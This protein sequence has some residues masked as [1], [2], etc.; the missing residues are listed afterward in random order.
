MQVLSRGCRCIEIDVWNGDAPA[1]SRD[2][3]KSPHADKGRGLSGSSLSSA[4]LSIVET[5]GDKYET[6]RLYLGDRAVAGHRRSRSP[7]ANRDALAVADDASP[8]TSAVS[9]STPQ[10]PRESGD[11]V[12][13][14]RVTPR[15]R[16]LPR[17][18]PIVTHGW[19]LTIPCGFRDVCEAIKESAFVDN[20]LPVIISLEV[21]AD[22]EQQEVMVSI[23]KE[24][25]HGLLV[26]EP[27][28][29]C[30]PRFRVP[31]L[32]ELRN[33]ILVKV[34]RAAAKMVAG[35]GSGEAPV[36]LHAVDDDDNTSRCH[37]DAALPPHSS[38][39]E[40][41]AP[42]AESSARARICDSLADLAVYTR[43]QRFE[44]LQTPHAKSP[45]HVLSMSENRILDM[46]HKHH[47]DVFV[48][49]KRYFMRAFPNVR[50]I[51]SSNPDPSLFWRKGVQMV[52]LNW[53]NL[54][55]GMMV[56]EGMFADEK[57]W[58]LKP[59]GYQSS[60][61]ASDT[62]ALAAP[63]CTMDLSITVFAGHNLP[64]TAAH[65]DGD[66]DYAASASAIRPL[67]KVE[68]H[69]ERPGGTDSSSGGVKENSY[70]RRTDAKK[71]SN[72]YFGSHGKTLEFR[73]IPKVVTE[74]S[75]VR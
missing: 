75:F 24:V 15:P 22:L 31:N 26:S 54:D 49:N 37:D 10:G 5:F 67:V 52:A 41:P 71:S 66:C 55:E 23:M 20:D 32:G 51:D 70:K 59:P 45:V 4:A 27:H 39:L 14:G 11:L 48:H 43:S 29:G 46:Y 30:D 35:Q 57:G 69:V 7:S 25:W 42:T 38:L 73:A 64:T 28:E 12:D 65:A 74:L 2:R 62:Q 44:G 36:V 50:R 3:T 9:V 56:N 61:K 33:K 8:R 18:E 19:T 21:H 47:R 34:K 63:G 40:K 68:L 6:A 16:A 13:V 53:Q 72:P 1:P 17:G 60:D 58:V